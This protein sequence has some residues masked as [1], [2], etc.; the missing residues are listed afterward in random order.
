MD[1][2]ENSS[3]ASILTQYTQFKSQPAFC[4]LVHRHIDMV[5]AAC[6]RQV[7]EPNL[8][9]DVTQAVFIILA[10]KAE[11]MKPDV[12]LAGWLIKTARYASL[13]AM[14]AESRRK[15]HEQKAAMMNSE[16]TSPNNV[17]PLWQQIAPVLDSALAKLNDDDRSAIVLRFMQDKNYEQIAGTLAISQDAAR[18][19]ISRA[20]ARLRQLMKK[21]GISATSDSLMIALPNCAAVHAPVGLIEKLTI[22]SNP[23]AS[24]SI[25][26]ARHTMMKIAPWQVVAMCMGLFLI[27]SIATILAVRSVPEKT[28][29]QLPVATLV[30]SFAPGTSNVNA[31]LIDPDGRPVSN[32][33]I[34]VPGTSIWRGQRT[35]AHGFFTLNGPRLRQNQF[36][37]F[38]QRSR[39]VALLSRNAD[40]TLPAQVKLQYSEANLDGVVLDSTG[41]PIAG[42]Q[43]HLSVVTPDGTT[44]PLESARTDG[45]GYYSSGIIP[46]G[47]GLQLIAALSNSPENH[48]T[49][50]PV[51]MK[52]PYQLEMPDLISKTQ[53]GN[54]GAATARVEYSGRVI[55]AQG[56]GN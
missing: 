6:L 31:Q 32:A 49:T 44:Y 13:A 1:N 10:N 39:R 26:I 8:A 53:T 42:T 18:Q 24:A 12:E 3:D 33:Y 23:P 11:T 27:A 9:E 37:A 2:M 5:Y 46:G 15:K 22:G 25:N 43:V 45:T 16:I 4:E 56:K 35:D 51:P 17:D 7:R 20:L 30:T 48:E 54:A 36:I 47:A 52:E 21:A 55:D 14:R 34:G 29:I 50:G 40:G 28:T 38:S 41:N 19:R